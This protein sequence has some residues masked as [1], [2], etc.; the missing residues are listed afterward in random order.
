[1]FNLYLQQSTDIFR[2][3]G[4]GS[5]RNWVVLLIGNLAVKI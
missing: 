3:D 1:M 4:G 5:V 2:L